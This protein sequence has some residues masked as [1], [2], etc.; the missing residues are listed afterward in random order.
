VEV[1]NASTTCTDVTAELTVRTAQMKSA[2]RIH[3][4]LYK[5]TGSISIACLFNSVNGDS[6]V[7]II[8]RPHRSTS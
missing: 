8:I 2:V 1:V 4:Y 7:C 3:I 5:H 6:L